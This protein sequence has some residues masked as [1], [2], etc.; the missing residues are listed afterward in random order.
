LKDEAI[1]FSSSAEEPKK[2]RTKEEG[3]LKRKMKKN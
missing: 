3:E 1:F 2:E